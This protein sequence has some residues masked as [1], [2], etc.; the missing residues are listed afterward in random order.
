VKAQEACYW[1]L[2]HASTV[3]KPTLGLGLGLRLGL[4]LGLACYWT[5]DHAGAGFNP[6]NIVN[7]INRLS[8]DPSPLVHKRA[9]CRRW[10]WCRLS[11]WWW[12]RG[13]APVGGGGKICK[14]VVGKDH[15]GSWLQVRC[16]HK[17]MPSVRAA[18][19]DRAHG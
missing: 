10:R 11:C 5:L 1:P 9:S 18:S 8:E 17:H 14:N 7:V 12:R 16:Q 4:G 15:V 19:R 13:W 6:T 3:F 2:D